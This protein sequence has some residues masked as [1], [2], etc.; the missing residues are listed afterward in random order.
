MQRLKLRL[1]APVMGMRLAAV[2]SF[3]LM[4][5]ACQDPVDSGGNA[6]ASV[7][8]AEEGAPVT[9]ALPK[10]VGWRDWVKVETERLTREEPA[11]VAQLSELVPL[12]TRSG[13]KRF[14]SPALQ[15]PWAT[16]LLL[17]RLMAQT[18]DVS[19]R[20]GI[21]E[22][23]GLTKG[24]YAEA[25]F[26]LLSTEPAPEVRE[27]LTDLLRDTDVY[28]TWQ[29]LEK[30]LGDESD[31]VR[32]EAIHVTMA[33]SDRKKV[34]P[35]VIKAL[36]NEGLETRRAAIFAVSVLRPA[37]A[38]P[39][40]ERMVD[41]RGALR[42]AA[43]LALYRVDPAAVRSRGDLDILAADPTMVGVVAEIRRGEP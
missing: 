13:K 3:G 16:P 42:A 2:A 1:F 11:L 29:A 9:A 23:L 39:A 14:V 33:R 7:A 24:P 8:T 35:H 34:E 41:G 12:T 30:A 37:G 21:A 43:L 17:G 6:P 10:G 36:E 22:A 15:N 18:D 4:L 5:A 28:T 27:A 31:M 40:L 32:A 26:D 38:K 19:T 25:L 20:R